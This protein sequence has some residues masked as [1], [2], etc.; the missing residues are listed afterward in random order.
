MPVYLLVCVLVTACTRRVAGALAAL[1]PGDVLVVLEGDLTPPDAH[2]LRPGRE[3][4]DPTEIDMGINATDVTSIDAYLAG[5]DHSSEETLRIGGRDFTRIE[6]VTLGTV[7]HY[8]T[9]IDGRVVTFGVQ[10]HNRAFA[11]RVLETLR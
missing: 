3:Y 6:I 8:V 10:T 2:A 7:Y 5:I 9:L 4:V 1:P 11:E